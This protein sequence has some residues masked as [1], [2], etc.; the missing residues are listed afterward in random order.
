MSWHP[1][2]LGHQQGQWSLQ[3]YT[4][5]CHCF[6]GYPWLL[7]N[8]TTPK[9]IHLYYYCEKYSLSPLK[10]RSLAFIEQPNISDPMYSVHQLFMW[11]LW[12]NWRKSIFYP[13]TAPNDSKC[14]S[15]VTL[16][17]QEPAASDCDV[18]MTDCFRVVSMDASF[19]FILWPPCF[20]TGHR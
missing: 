3:T 14:W 1:M 11:F 7:Y 16:S 20:N 10:L 13:I 17:I 5:F 18:T 2:V 4:V 9:A 12:L 15:I 8:S 19:V 6:I